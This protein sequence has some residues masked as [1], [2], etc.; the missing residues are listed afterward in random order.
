MSR[1]Q[2]NSCGGTYED[3]LPSGIA[4]MHACPLDRVDA[5]GNRVPIATPR[6]ENVQPGLLIVV[7]VSGSAQVFDA[8]GALLPV[9]AEHLPIIAEGL[10][11]TLLEP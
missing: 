10:G 5:A 9:D 3:T 7:G 2:C 1:W 11:R 8:T 4:Y 6:D